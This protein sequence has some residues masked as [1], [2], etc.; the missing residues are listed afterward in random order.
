MEIW[1][2]T[3]YIR[4]T[5]LEGISSSPTQ[6]T[7]SFILSL[8]VVYIFVYY[9]YCEIAQRNVLLINVEQFLF[10]RS[11]LY[12]LDACYCGD[13]FVMDFCCYSNKMLSTTIILQF[14]F[15]NNHL[16]THLLSCCPWKWT[17]NVTTSFFVCR[18]MRSQ[19]IQ[20]FFPEG[21]AV[22]Q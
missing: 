6:R 13:L 3:N 7:S 16:N 15:L 19:K 8:H 4:A 14:K 9:K 17:E 12:F 5:G 22:C 2:L 20:C 11:I 18:G 1:I 10:K 21:R